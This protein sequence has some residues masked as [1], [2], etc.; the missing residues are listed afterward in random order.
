V[1]V[2]IVSLFIALIAFS[3]LRSTSREVSSK[4]RGPSGTYYEDLAQKRR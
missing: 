2:I 1:P 4:R 3:L